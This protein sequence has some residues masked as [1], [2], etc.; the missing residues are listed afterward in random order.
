M[1]IFQ[2]TEIVVIF[3]KMIKVIKMIILAHARPISCLSQNNRRRDARETHLHWLFLPLI[4]G[5]FRGG[6]FG[7]RPRRATLKAIL[8]HI[9]NVYPVYKQKNL[10]LAGFSAH[11]P[12]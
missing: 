12:G 7:S 1:I 11:P 10:I 8:E 3:L 9:E 5:E 2:L 4:N 6:V